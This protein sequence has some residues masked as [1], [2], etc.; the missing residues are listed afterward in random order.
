MFV[1][2]NFASLAVIS[3]YGFKISVKNMLKFLMIGYRGRSIFD[4]WHMVETHCGPYRYLSHGHSGICNRLMRS[5]I[6][7]EP[8][9][10]DGYNL[11][12]G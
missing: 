9:C 4:Y 2:A 7:S 1:P 5:V 6:H 10:Q 3:K 12:W 11:V 8:N